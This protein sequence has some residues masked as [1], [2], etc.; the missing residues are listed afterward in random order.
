MWSVESQTK[1]LEGHVAEL[2]VLPALC[3]FLSC[4]FHRL[5][6]SETP[7]DFQRTTRCYI[8]QDRSLYNHQCDNLKSYI[9]LPVLSLRGLKRNKGSESLILYFVE[10]YRMEYFTCVAHNRRSPLEILRI[11]S[12]V[13][14]I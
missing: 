9:N 5:F 10:D 13:C 4:L 11:L 1:F 8:P 2:R 6:F 3:W 14:L 12:N 7:I